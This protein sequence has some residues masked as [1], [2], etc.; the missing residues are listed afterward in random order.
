MHTYTPRHMHADRP[1][2]IKS[3]K[4]TH[5]RRHVQRRSHT[6]LSQAPLYRAAHLKII[7][8]RGSRGCK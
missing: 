1:R 8:T 6:Y 3:P 2:D 5:A 7:A 4:Y